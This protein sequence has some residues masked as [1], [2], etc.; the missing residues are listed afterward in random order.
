VLPVQLLNA[1]AACH[2][3]CVRS[4]DPKIQNIPERTYRARDERGEVSEDDSWPWAGR[5]VSKLPL[6]ALSGWS[7]DTCHVALLHLRFR[8]RVLQNALFLFFEFTISA[9]LAISAWLTWCMY[10][11]GHSIWVL[12]CSCVCALICRRYTLPHGCYICV[13]I[14]SLS[15]FDIHIWWFD[16][17]DMLFYC[18]EAHWCMC[19][20]IERC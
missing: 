12:Q 1:S 7:F 16:R 15:V 2:R 17:S 4:K 3:A 5:R 8:V 20:D 11:V 18:T 6:L 10:A 9:N 19:C 14:A 13:H